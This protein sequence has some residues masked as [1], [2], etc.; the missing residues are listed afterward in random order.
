MATSLTPGACS[1]WRGR[2]SAARSGTSPCSNG[3]RDPARSRA[4]CPPRPARHRFDRLVLPALLSAALVPRGGMLG[5]AS[6][7]LAVDLACD[8][9]R[10][11][12]AVEA[13]PRIFRMS[14]S[15]TSCCWRSSGSARDPSGALRARRGVYDVATRPA[16]AVGIDLLT[17]LTDL[18]EA[19]DACTRGH[20][21]TLSRAT[22]SEWPGAMHLQDGRGT[23]RK[24]EQAA[25]V[26]DVG[27]L[28]TPTGDPRRAPPARARA[29]RGDRNASA[30]NQ[31]DM[32][33]TVDDPDI[34]DIVAA[35]RRAPSTAAAI[36]TVS[37]GAGSALR[38]AHHRGRR[39]RFGSITSDRACR[40]ASTQKKVLDV[41]LPRERDRQL[42]RR[43]CHRRLK[44]LRRATF[45]R[46]PHVRHGPAPGR[47]LALQATCAGLCFQLAGASSLLPEPS[48][49][50]GLLALAAALRQLAGSASRRIDRHAPALEHRAFASRRARSRAHSPSA[51]ERRSCSGRRGPS[52]TASPTQHEARCDHAARRRLADGRRGAPATGNQAV[53][54]TAPGGPGAA[55]E[56]AA[57]AA[58]ERV[59][60]C[61]ALPQRRRFRRSRL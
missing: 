42:E 48:A 36:P 59:C 20:R 5:A 37:P 29:N 53:S 14:S 10:R 39:T 60:R 22:P 33:A 30:D 57:R 11:G 58:D 24:S 27:K 23:P 31:A 47:G 7:A 38:L 46:G 21:R 50:A 54:T 13:L 32:L 34:A 19:R 41:L 1:R 15:P 9:Q 35:H 8:R 17:T 4:F 61:A 26:H 51:A 16:P 56:P 18:L 3:A 12:R 55:R 6:V 2:S 44:A 49:R 43:G 45:D 52:R 28:H 25:S 40:R